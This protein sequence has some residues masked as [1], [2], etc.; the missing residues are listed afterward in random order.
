MKRYALHLVRAVLV[1]AAACVVAVA[2]VPAQVPADAVFSGFEPNGE[3][4]FELAGAPLKNVEIFHSERAGAFLIMAP[5]LSSPLLINTRTGQV[6]SVHLMKVAKR[7]NGTID[8]LADATF[9]QAGSFRLEGAEVHFEVKGK[10]AKLLRKDDLVGLHGAEKL[11][12][13]KADY[14]FRAGQYSPKPSDLAA[15][16]A[17]DK[18]VRVLIYFGTW[19]PT[20]SRLVP[21]VLK[22]AEELEG[23]KI[24]FE[25]YGLPR[26]MNTDPRTERDKVTGVP[27]GI[28]YVGNREVGR[29]SVKE[30]NAPEAGIKGILAGS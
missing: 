26:Q 3:F 25:Y 4:A 6:E 5:E 22:V 11:L 8:L 13:Y 18:E 20:C 19:C 1:A 29:L 15:L 12:G 27:T 28:V 17:E 21:R 10:P 14:A 16:R 24:H 2:A 23:S 9:N 30:L 7:G